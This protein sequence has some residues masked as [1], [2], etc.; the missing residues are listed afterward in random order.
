MNSTNIETKKFNFFNYM[1]E[2]VLI[3]IDSISNDPTIEK[4][5]PE[6]KK[7]IVN[8]IVD[9]NSKTYFIEYNSN[10]IG[11]V[12]LNLLDE[13]C[14]FSYCLDKKFRKK[15]LGKLI[16]N[17]LEEY[18]FEIGIKKIKFYVEIGNEDS[19]N[20]FKNNEYGIRRV[21]N[22]NYYVIEKEPKFIQNK[23]SNVH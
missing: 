4:F 22:C 13:E 19:L 12:Y 23:K 1:N 16:R 18:L 20:S 6:Y 17:E 5:Y 14:T 9:E 8:P 3:F 2:K 15:G 21:H 10:V 11:M 7:H